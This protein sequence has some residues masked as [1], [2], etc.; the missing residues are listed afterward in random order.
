MTRPIVD[1]PPPGRDAWSFCPYCNAGYL[2]GS[3][4]ACAREYM[5]CRGIV[6]GLCFVFAAACVLAAIVLLAGAWRAS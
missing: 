1:R 5:R 4:H 6:A 3:V 2:T